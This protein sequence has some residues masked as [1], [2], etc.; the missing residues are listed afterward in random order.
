[1]G[2]KDLILLVIIALALLVRMWAFTF[3]PRHEGPDA[4]DY[5]LIARGVAASVKGEPIEDKEEFL[6]VAGRRG[7]LYPLCLA[8]LFSVF[9]ARHVAVAGFHIVLDCLTCLLVYFIGRRIFSQR[10]GL[11]AALL[12]A[13]Y[14]GFI[15]Y[16]GLISQ[17]PAMTFLLVLLAYAIVRIQTQPGRANLFLVGLLLGCIS[18][19]RPSYQFLFIMLIPAFLHYLRKQNP[20]CWR[21]PFTSFLAGTVAIVS[22]WLVFSY[23]VS[24][25]AILYKSGYWASY[26]TLRNDGWVTDDYFPLVDEELYQ[27]LVSMGYPAPPLGTLLD[28][29]HVL[30]GSVYLRLCRNWVRDH[31]Y[32]TI[33]QVLKRIYRIWFYVEAPPGRWHNG[34]VGAQLFFH[35][36][37]IV[38]ALVGIPLS[39]FLHHR[40]W[41]LYLLILYANFHILMIGIPR[42]AVPS[43][44]FVLL[45]SSYAIMLLFTGAKKVFLP[46][47]WKVLALI[48]MFIVT[49]LFFYS[50]SPIG[51]GAIL[52]LLP[53]LNPETAYHLTVLMANVNL[54]L[55]ALMTYAYLRESNARKAVAKITIFVALTSLFLNNALITDENWREW[56]R[57]LKDT[58]TQ[59]VHR[60]YVPEEL[61]RS[62]SAKAD[63]FIDMMAGTGRSY[64]LLVTVN[65]RKAKSYRGGLTS[66]KEKFLKRF[67]GFYEYFFFRSYGLR[68][69]DLRQWYR[70]PL[71]PEDLKAANPIV[72]ACSI[73][74]N[75]D[76]KKNYVH[77]FGDYTSEATEKGNVFDGP[78]IPSTN[79]DTSLYKIM[80]YGGDCRFRARLK[81]G[82]NKVESLLCRKGDCQDQNLSDSPGIQTGRYRIL[83]RLT[84]G[85][86]EVFL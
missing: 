52:F 84:R 48:G 2:K 62:S 29:D 72:I 46:L 10:V 17:E 25:Q 34:A 69:E 45:L 15:Y 66:E 20:T 32:E 71:D 79:Q 68:P 74:G 1:M 61:G 60:I 16:S 40:S 63:L 37:L 42:Y 19:Y 64:D 73:S 11:L 7:W 82:S 47:N 75:P 43:M 14:P 86:T 54:L 24:G 55:I 9:G 6:K 49:A 30:P 13:V 22:A 12:S 51:M 36:F 28:L 5:K 56:W 23:T 18:I 76:G 27:E 78:I 81:L 83:I 4:S 65:G 3:L 85:E 31:P 70:V 80:P 50:P 57:T 35:R 41:I 38:L 67:F 21:A 39:L 58:D 59:V 44:P 33:S 26:E 53:V 77:I 8:V